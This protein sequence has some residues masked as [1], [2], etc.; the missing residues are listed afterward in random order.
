MEKEIIILLLTVLF[1]SGLSVG[2]VFVLFSSYKKRMVLEELHELALKEKEIDSII[3]KVNLV[4][5]KK[6]LRHSIISVGVNFD[7]FDD[8]EKKE[9]LLNFKGINKFLEK[10]FIPISKPINSNEILCLYKI[11]NFKICPILL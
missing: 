9:R 11:K 2:I 10:E 1:T 5:S 6:M 4:A 8:F 7:D 3:N